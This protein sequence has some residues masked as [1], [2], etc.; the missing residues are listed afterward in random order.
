MTIEKEVCGVPA[1][2]QWIKNLT[3]AAWVAVEVRVQFPALL[4]GLRFQ[5]Y[6][7]FNP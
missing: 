1:V 6:V 2:V 3:V 7:G 4:S 5:P